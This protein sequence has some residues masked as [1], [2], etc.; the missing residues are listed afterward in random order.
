[1]RTLVTD[2]LRDIAYYLHG[3]SCYRLSIRLIKSTVQTPSTRDY[4]MPVK[5]MQPA[6][7]SP[8]IYT[9][10]WL[11]KQFLENVDIM[12]YT[13]YAVRGYPTNHA[14]SMKLECFRVFNVSQCTTIIIMLN[15]AGDL[16]KL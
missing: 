2:R 6:N 5:E 13:R 9:I 4:P 3:I 10:Y 1:M 14:R 7:N 8:V 15:L 16:S 12:P 11:V